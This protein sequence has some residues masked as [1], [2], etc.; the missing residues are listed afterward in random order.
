MVEQLTLNQ[1]VVG[2]SPARGTNLLS[3]N[4]ATMNFR[5]NLPFAVGFTAGFVALASSIQAEVVYDNSTNSR[6]NAFS[7][8]SQFHDAVVRTFGDE[9]NLA[10]VSRQVTQFIIGYVGDFNTLNSS[11]KIT[12]SLYA[13]DG[14]NYSGPGSHTERPSTLLW[15]SDP[16]QLANGANQL[17]FAVPNILVPTRFTWAVTFS[18][19]T[20]V[21]GDSAGLIFSGPPTIGAPLNDGK[22]GSYDDI[23]IQT[24]PNRADSWALFTNLKDDLGNSLPGS[25]YAKVIAVPE[26]STWALAALGGGLLWW[27]ARQRRG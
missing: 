21:A 8:N 27:S 7:Q 10:G 22:I 9:I 15:Q 1:F 11:D 2:S 4:H 23:W 19:T 18:G 12:L 14:A 13:N 25:F 20:G 6:T 3:V 26:P 5:S 24:D 17:T 16:F